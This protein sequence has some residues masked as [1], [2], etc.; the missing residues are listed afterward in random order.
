MKTLRL[1]PI[2][3]LVFTQISCGQETDTASSLTDESPTTAVQPN[4]PPA[5]VE[6][7]DSGSGIVLPESA[8]W[9]DLLWA[10][11]ETA[12]QITIGAEKGI[13][14]Y[15][16]DVLTYPGEQT[17][18]VARVHNARNLADI[19]GVTVT[20]YHNDTPIGTAVTDDEGM[21]KVEVLP[22]AVGDY[23][24]TAKISNVTDEMPEGLLT[25]KPTLL[26]V[27]AREK[28]TPFVVID[29]DHTT[30][31]SSFLAVLTGQAEPMA[32]AQKVLRAISKQ[33][34]LIYLTH[35]PEEMGITT[36]QWL[37]DHSFPRAP[38]LMAELNQSIGSSG[39]FKTGRIAEI[40]EAFPNLT[41]G[42]GDKL[43]DAEAYLANGMTAYLIPH[44]DDDDSDDMHEM[45]DDIDAM[46]QSNRLNV[47]DTWAEIEVG[48]FHKI[49]YPAVK[50]TQRL[51]RR[52]DEI[53]RRRRDD[54]DD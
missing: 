10:A 21:A 36:K 40:I 14:F 45:A 1:I 26:V 51:R 6:E 48:L 41:V 28:E 50:Y 11:A 35:R 24:F 23:Y 7:A 53:R 27:S 2:L 3:L 8:D 52:A 38:L 15:A 25:V 32:D 29:L 9:R 16:Y 13:L 20:F 22:D 44:F 43:S 42:I 39:G 12:E 46:T 37:I 4:D 33:Y 49:R 47:V 18:L 34:S 19:P 31:G 54:D 30:V 17:E 5:V